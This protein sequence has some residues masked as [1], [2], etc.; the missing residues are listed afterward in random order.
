MSLASYGLCRNQKTMNEYRGLWETVHYNPRVGAECSLRALQT[1][2]ILAS[3]SPAV[4]SLTSSPL[5]F[6]CAWHFEPSGILSVGI[7]VFGKQM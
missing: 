7:K 6:L 5:Q 2:K 4:T 1:Q 3:P